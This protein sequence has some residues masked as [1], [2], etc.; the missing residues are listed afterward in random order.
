MRNLFA[1]NKSA[2]IMSTESRKHWQT[3][4]KQISPS[5]GQ[6]R[7]RNTK[8]N[9]SFCFPLLAKLC[10]RCLLNHRKQRL[11]FSGASISM[12]ICHCLRERGTIFV[13]SLAFCDYLLEWTSY[14]STV[15]RDYVIFE[16]IF[17]RI[18]YDNFKS[19]QYERCLRRKLRGR[20]ALKQ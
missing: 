8:E 13:Y 15:C 6:F 18:T 16:R 14:L 11:V 17:R 3:T 5:D 9:I 20:F 4:S 19:L 2:G 12:Q 10:D 7:F 1:I